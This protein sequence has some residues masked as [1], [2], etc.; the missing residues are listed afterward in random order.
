MCFSFSGAQGTAT[1]DS[2]VEDGAS[3]W[4]R[5][6]SSRAR[7]S[8]CDL[9]LPVD[10]VIGERFEADAERREMDGA[11]VPEGWMGL[12]IGPRRPRESPRRE[13]EAAGTV[14]W[15]GPMGAFE[16]EPFAPAPARS[17][18]PSPGPGI[19]VVGGGDCPRR[20]RLRA[21]RE[22][23]W[24]STGGGASLELMEGK[25]LPGGG[26]AARCMTLAR[27]PLV[28]AQLEDAQDD[29]ETADFLERFVR[30]AGR[31]SRRGGRRPPPVYRLGVAVD[32]R[33]PLALAG[34]RAEHP[35]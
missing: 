23:D 24:V 28:A 11:E 6:C 9:G 33:A 26:G 35:R 13:I 15:N 7:D 4:P 29:A 8:S 2:L 14:F 18:R 30:R 5:S 27:S 22:V 21:R 3:S 1:G 34:G 19:T 25:G 31:A 20:W 10:L 17:P 32:R 16:L 12:D